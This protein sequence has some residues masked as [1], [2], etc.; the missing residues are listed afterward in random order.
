[1]A[2]NSN[3]LWSPSWHSRSP[4]Q[5][6]S[7]YLKFPQFLPLLLY[8]S[9]TL[10][11]FSKLFGNRP[12]VWS[13]SNGVSWLGLRSWNWCCSCGLWS[14][15]LGKLLSLPRNEWKANL[16]HIECS[17][18]AMGR[19]EQGSTIYSSKWW[20]SCSQTH[21]TIKSHSFNLHSWPRVCWKL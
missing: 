8:Y 17:R 19:M 9:W 13:F 18:D 3:A 6:V 2:G 4:W 12:R 5:R 1:M 15:R 7:S 10:N 21:L 16:I 11:S 20:F 14:G